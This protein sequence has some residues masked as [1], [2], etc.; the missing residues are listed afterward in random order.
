VHAYTSA[1]LLQDTIRRRVSRE[2]RSTALE[3]A[4]L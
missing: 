4:L 1:R 3:S 2:H